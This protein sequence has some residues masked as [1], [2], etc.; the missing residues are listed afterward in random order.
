MDLNY[1]SLEQ[2]S[3][4]LKSNYVIQIATLSG[5][6]RK[7]LCR[8]FNQRGHQNHNQLNLLTGIFLTL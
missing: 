3:M 5:W 1:Y 8:C 2:F 6:P 7:I 4:T